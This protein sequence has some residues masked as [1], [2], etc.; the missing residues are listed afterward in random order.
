MSCSNAGGAPEVPRP[1]EKRGRQLGRPVRFQPDGAV[2]GHGLLPPP[3]C[4][5]DQPEAGHD[6]TGQPRADDWTGHGGLAEP[7]WQL[8]RRPCVLSS[9]R[10]NVFY[11]LLLL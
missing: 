8:I 1:Q 2:L 4:Q 6:Q 10:E 11:E 7:L 3:P 5:P 9:R